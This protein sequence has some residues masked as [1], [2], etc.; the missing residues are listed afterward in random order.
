MN[1][2]IK[3]YIEKYASKLAVNK[4]VSFTEAEKRAG[5]F[6]YAQAQITDWRHLLSEE[7]IKLTSIQ[8]ATYAEQLSLCTGKTVTEN[9]TTVEASKEYQKA[10]E[11]LESVENDIAYL[12]AYYDIFQNAHVFFRQMA[13][14]ESL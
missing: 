3:E 13:K 10:R 12:K 8:L 2:E 14:G 7:K 4:M 6:L 5:E 9:K 1:A 11:D